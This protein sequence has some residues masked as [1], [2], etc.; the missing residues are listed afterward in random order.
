MTLP[1][2]IT[3]LLG[4]GF[5]EV[6]PNNM[7]VLATMLIRTA[8]D[9][10]QREG[11]MP[12]LIIQ[13]TALEELVEKLPRLLPLL[14]EHGLDH[15]RIPPASRPIP[16]NE[17]PTI[18]EAEQ[19]GSVAC[20]TFAFCRP[21]AEHTAPLVYVETGDT[22]V[23]EAQRGGTYFVMPYRAVL[24]LADAI[25]KVLVAMR[26]GR[27]GPSNAGLDFDFTQLNF[28]WN[29]A[30]RKI[31]M[32]R[33]YLS[34]FLRSQGIEALPPMQELMDLLSRL[35]MLHIRGGRDRI[36]AMEACLAASGFMLNVHD[37]ATITPARREMDN[38]MDALHLD[39]R[40]QLRDPMAAESFWAWFDA[41]VGPIQA[42]ANEAGET[43]AFDERYANV[44]QLIADSGLSRTAN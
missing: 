43:A 30:T 39:V 40:T 5:G 28:K 21:S 1:Q 6:L 2:P 36:P 17:G 27:S 19:T 18:D 38:K 4:V 9:G 3:T 15:D 10:H 23:A 34:V 11:I 24:E 37:P 14:K 32:N 16:W 12:P 42:A 29:E 33:G 31:T 26:S 13:A 8:G 44:A 35:Y 41:Q 22:H 20:T 7:G 25:P